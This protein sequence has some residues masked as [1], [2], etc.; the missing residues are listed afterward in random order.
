MAGS[1]P[2][3]T[4]VPRAVFMSELEDFALTRWTR[5]ARHGQELRED[6]T[7]GDALCQ[8]PAPNG[9]RPESA[10]G[11]RRASESVP[12]VQGGSAM[13]R[14]SGSRSSAG[15]DGRAGFGALGEGVMRHTSAAACR[16]RRE[17][18]LHR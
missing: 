1:G 9:I 8:N 13:L 6:V 11:K 2:G 15:S 4:G 14:V 17:R 16:L 12:A 5:T 3:A 18:R 7:F 10:T